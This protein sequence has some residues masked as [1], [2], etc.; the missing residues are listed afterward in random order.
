MDERIQWTREE[1]GLRVR[2][3][4]RLDTRFPFAMKIIS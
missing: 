3:P 2:I 1:S 4:E